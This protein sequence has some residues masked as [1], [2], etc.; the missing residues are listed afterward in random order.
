MSLY[1][2]LQVRYNAR[3]LSTGS[4][5]GRHISAAILKGCSVAESTL[6]C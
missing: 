3:G 1:L 2:H 4:R 6:V 5:D